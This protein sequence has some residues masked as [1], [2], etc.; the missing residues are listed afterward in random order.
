[1]QINFDL[2]TMNRALFLNWESLKTLMEFRL[3][4]LLNPKIHAAPF[5]DADY[6][7]VETGPISSSE[8]ELLF[9]AAGADKDDRE[10]HNG[11]KLA[12]ESITDALALKLIAPEM[13][14]PVKNA[15]A[16]E[17]GLYFIDQ[18]FSYPK[19]YPLTEEAAYESE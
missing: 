1:M 14:F 7:E 8:M 2:W 3:S 13:P 19:V 9:E 18:G 5:Q 4:F 17:N 11:E 10:N 12:L 16:V 15:V 6:W